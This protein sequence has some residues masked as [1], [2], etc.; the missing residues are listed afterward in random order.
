MNS[1]FNRH[2]PE[3]A[4]VRLG[5]GINRVYQ[6]LEVVWFERG[7]WG[8]SHWRQQGSTLRS[9]EGAVINGVWEERRSWWA[10]DDG[11]SLSLGAA[12][13]RMVRS[14]RPGEERAATRGCLS[15]LLHMMFSLAR[16]SILPFSVSFFFWSLK[17]GMIIGLQGYSAAWN[18]AHKLFGKQCF[19]QNTKD[20]DTPLSRGRTSG[21]FTYLRFALLCGATPTQLRRK[22]PWALEIALTDPVNFPHSI[23]PR[24]LLKD[25][26]TSCQ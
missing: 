22:G 15:K 23:G 11:E 13:P 16:V 25:Q 1:S 7:N 3:A 9:W 17:W 20:S 19:Y 24:P 8:K 6:N 4:E 5:C 12:R 2:E 21:P 18:Q 14:Y 10:R 26:W